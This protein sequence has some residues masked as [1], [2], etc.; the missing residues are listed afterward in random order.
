MPRTSIECL[1]V[2]V[3]LLQLFAAVMVMVSSK[4]W[5]IL[6]SARFIILFSA[7]VHLYSFSSSGS[8]TSRTL[9]FKMAAFTSSGPTV[10][11]VTDF[12]LQVFSCQYLK[13]ANG[14]AESIDFRRRL[15][16][17]STLKHVGS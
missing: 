14:V 3:K 15:L 2:F 13:Q 6:E 4:A 7:N 9:Y 12:Y 10:V 5:P 17:L 16:R 11:S 1:Q 8:K